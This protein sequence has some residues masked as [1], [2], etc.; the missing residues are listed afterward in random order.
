[1]AT[2][3][4]PT[5]EQRAAVV[6]EAMRWIG[7][8]YHHAAKLFGVGVD[9]ATLIAAVYE[10]VGLIE[11]V[12]IPP[13]SPQWHLHRKIEKYKDAVL[14][15]ARAIPEADALPGDVVLYRWGH[16]KAHGGIIG[17]RGWPFIIHA[18]SRAGQVIEADGRGGDLEGKQTEFFTYW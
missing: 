17:A 6:A 11:P 10:N 2:K 7:T 5:I 15:R 9:C 4:L 18:Y 3:D 12:D 16:V 14:L 1:M 13:Y 8:P